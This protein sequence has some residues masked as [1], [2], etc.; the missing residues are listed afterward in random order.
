MNHFHVESGLSGYGP[1]ASDTD[2]F[3]VLET[4]K[5]VA[6][7]IRGELATWIDFE[8]D[9]AH[10]YVE[11]GDFESAW[12]LHVHCEAMEILAANLNNARATAPLYKGNPELW[13][14]TIMS[15]VAEHFPY[16]VNEGRSKIYVWECAEK[17]CL[18]E[19]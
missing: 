6:D 16:N 14:R 17:E 19:E 4:P 2:G 15:I 8:N 5:Q 13:D 9:S 11:D 3:T 7:M 1:Q 10:S 12:N 18:T